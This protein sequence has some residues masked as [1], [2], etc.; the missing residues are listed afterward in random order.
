MRHN[1]Y[2]RPSVG[3]H[4]IIGAALDEMDALDATTGAD[5]YPALGGGYG[6]PMVGLKEIIGAMDPSESDFFRMMAAAG[7]ET[8]AGGG[9]ALA[10]LAARMA[11]ARQIDPNAVVVRERAEDTRREFHLGFDSGPVLVAAGGA[12]QVQALPQVTFRSERLVVPSFLAPFFTIDNIIVG[13]DS[14]TA[15]GFSPVP[16][17]TY[18]E[19]AVG[20]RLS[21]KTANLGNTII[22][23]G[24]NVDVAGHRFRA[25]LIGTATDIA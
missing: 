22:L 23:A 21:L 16:A 24:T 2:R 9:G 8:P 13:K 7:Q 3:Y 25:T 15:V 14:Q 17:S 19:V 5:M 1:Y 6:N 10:A 11:E 12:F 4:D 20:V 18:S